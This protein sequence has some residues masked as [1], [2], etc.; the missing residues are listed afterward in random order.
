[1]DEAKKKA[2]SRE[3]KRVMSATIAECLL[4]IRK[5]IHECAFRSGYERKTGHRTVSV[6]HKKG[7][8]PEPLNLRPPHFRSAS[9]HADSSSA[10]NA[11]A[12]LYARRA[13][14]AR[15]SVDGPPCK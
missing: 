10:G 8:A 14:D 12:C 2:A 1:M 6:K 5:K 7:R 13:V 3:S 11:L 9:L 15:Y 4:Q